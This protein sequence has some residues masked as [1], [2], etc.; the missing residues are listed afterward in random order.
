M[1]RV[2]IC[3]STG[4]ILDLEHCRKNAKIEEVKSGGKIIRRDILRNKNGEICYIEDENVEAKKV[5]WDATTDKAKYV[6][7]DG[8]PVQE[9]KAV[10][11]RNNVFDFV[12]G[13]AQHPETVNRD[14][15]AEDK[16]VV[17]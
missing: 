14:L 12:T 16:A 13:K 9:I 2:A 4:S 10:V 1:H 6:L 7:K 3:L 11:C 5:T 15:E 17:T 8:K